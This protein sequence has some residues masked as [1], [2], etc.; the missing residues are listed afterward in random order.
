MKR[1]LS[2]CGI[3]PGSNT[4][5]FAAARI[6]LD[7]GKVILDYAGTLDVS[8]TPTQHV[9]FCRR[10]GALQ[11]RLYMLGVELRYL[12]NRF[13]VDKVMCEDAFIGKNPQSF[14]TLVLCQATIREAMYDINICA[15]MELF[16]PSAGKGAVGTDPQSG[17]KELVMAAVR[18]LPDVVYDDEIDLTGLS[19][20][21][22]DAIAQ[23]MI[24]ANR[25]RLGVSKDKLDLL[26]SM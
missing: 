20:H 21:A 23:I 15:T 3:D 9:D 16:Q 1:Y 14:K 11:T 25:V 18:D 7:T 2:V 5:G 10:H 17:D 6:C 4:L 24:F 13:R 26:G 19:E 8:K 22:S 12:F